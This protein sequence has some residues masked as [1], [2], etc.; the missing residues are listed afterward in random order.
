MYGKHLPA[1]QELCTGIESDKCRAKSGLGQPVPRPGCSRSIYLLYPKVPTL[2]DL[3]GL[4][5]LQSSTS[6]ADE[7]GNALVALGTRRVHK[8]STTAAQRGPLGIYDPVD[9]SALSD[10]P[11]T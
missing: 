10:I 7:V 11:S 3:C 4:S 2:P 8:R 9:V 1:I 6:G 5:P